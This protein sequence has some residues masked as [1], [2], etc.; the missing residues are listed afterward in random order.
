[1][2]KY[3]GYTPRQ[4][5]ASDG[6]FS[7]WSPYDPYF[8]KERVRGIIG[9]VYAEF[10]LQDILPEVR[11]NYSSE[12]KMEQFSEIATAARHSIDMFC[13]MVFDEVKSQRYASSEEYPLDRELVFIPAWRGYRGQNFK[14]TAK[15]YLRDDEVGVLK[16]M[17]RA[18]LLSSFD[19]SFLCDRISDFEGLVSCVEGNVPFAWSEIA[20][21]H[22][23]LKE[24]KGFD[25]NPFDAPYGVFDEDDPYD[26]FREPDPA[27][28]D[29]YDPFREPDP[30]PY[31]PYDPFREPND[32]G[33]GDDEFNPFR[34]DDDDDDPFDDYYED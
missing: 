7:S 32:D 29:P 20:E 10:L 5:H 12:E 13:Q 19:G 9:D 8:V 15:F 33:G 17:H 11:K 4:I 34:D 2:E 31:D 23:P 21:F 22:V 24:P 6:L 3:S 14:L 16:I 27:P 26:P 1:V 28:Y 25:E 18:D 30:A